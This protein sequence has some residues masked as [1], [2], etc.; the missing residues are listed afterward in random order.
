MNMSRY[1][2]KGKKAYVFAIL[3]T[4]LNLIVNILI[5]DVNQLLSNYQTIIMS[6]IPSLVALIAVYLAGLSILLPSII[7]EEVRKLKPSSNQNLQTVINIFVHASKIAVTLIGY[8]LFVYLLIL[9]P[10]QLPYYIYIV[11]NTILFFIAI[12][13]L[14]L[15]L[16]IT[17]YMLKLLIE[18]YNIINDLKDNK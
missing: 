9:V 2:K 17:I 1:I 18:F 7:S 8:S 10:I 4:A 16:Q 13:L 12:Y 15:L 6:L 14:F 11:V 5:V 3:F